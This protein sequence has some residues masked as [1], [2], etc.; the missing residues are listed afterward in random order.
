MKDSYYIF[1]TFTFKLMTN[2]NQIEF[3]LFKKSIFVR[4]KNQHS[5]HYLY[6][7]N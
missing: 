3:F 7:T 2:K 1:Q 6:N 5:H 4:K